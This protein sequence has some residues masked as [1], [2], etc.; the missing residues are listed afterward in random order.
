MKGASI[1]IAIALVL[2]YLAVSGTYKCFGIFLKC[3]L[4]GVKCDC[5]PEGAATAQ[6]GGVPTIKAPTTPPIVG[7]T[8]PII[9]ATGKSPTISISDVLGVPGGVMFP[10]RPPLT[11]PF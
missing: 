1:M 5:L 7:T 10:P 3:L 2:A 11:I 4:G 9:D 6:A 8:P